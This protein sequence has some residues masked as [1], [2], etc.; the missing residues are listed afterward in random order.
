MNPVVA[1]GDYVVIEITDTGVG[2]TPDAH[3][4]ALEPFFTTRAR[5]RTGSLSMVYGFV[6]QSGGQLE[7]PPSRRPWNRCTDSPAARRPVRLRRGRRRRRLPIE[8]LQ[9][10]EDHPAGSKT[11]TRCDRP[12]RRNWP[13]SA[14]AS[15][16]RKA[17]DVA[18]RL[19]DQ[20][21]VVGVDLVLSDVVMP[22]SWTDSRWR[23]G[24]RHRLVSKWYLASGFVGHQIRVRNADY[25]RTHNTDETLPKDRGLHGRSKRP[26]PRKTAVGL[27]GV[28]SM[29]KRLLIVDDD[30]TSTIWCSGQRPNRPGF[31]LE[32][33]TSAK[34][35]CPGS[36]HFQR[37]H[38]YRSTSS[39]MPR[40]DGGRVAV[41]TGEPGIAQAA[42]I[43]SAVSH[44]AF[45]KARCG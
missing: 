16:K 41:R 6:T 17:A 8:I 40:L 45:A 26:W 39:A 11:T 28:M 3:A 18:R 37:R 25:P 2:M 22:G 15:S 31:S 24:F 7:D 13:P 38:L 44:R 33:F 19:L 21:G 20:A 14:T 4:N 10:P 1:V 42:Y 36:A 32:A 9:R 12:W 43:S 23:S 34:S 35:C 30:P 29:E 5:S 27:K